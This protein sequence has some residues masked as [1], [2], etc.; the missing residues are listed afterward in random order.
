M[1]TA[2]VKVDIEEFANFFT[3][4]FFI[5]K[6]KKFPTPRQIELI[7]KLSLLERSPIIY[8]EISV[9]IDQP[10]VEMVALILLEFDRW[11][12][13]KYSTITNTKYILPRITKVSDLVLTYAEFQDK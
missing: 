13:K 1:Y 6:T 10:N 7:I 5:L 11:R 4:K 12:T 8:E 3:N 2:R 9:L